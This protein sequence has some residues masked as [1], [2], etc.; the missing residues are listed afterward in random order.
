VNEIEFL[1]NAYIN[2][3]FPMADAITNEIC[4]HSPTYRA[5]FPIYDIKPHRSLKQY[6]KQN[7][8]TTTINKNFPFVINA[9]AN[10][11]E[12]WISNEIINLY[13]SLHK[14]GFAHS[15]ESWYDG[16]I[17]GGLY[18]IS[19]GG[20]FFGESMF[21]YMSN[22]SK[23]AFY[24]LIEHLKKKEFELLDTQFINE[25]TKLLGAIEIPR[26]DYIKKLK[27]AIKLERSFV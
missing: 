23:I 14:Y 19:I 9:C 15:I 3:Y 10:R 18:G 21:S 20:A 1:I 25:H 4:F 8:I 11:E 26:K 22:A 16:N 2:G 13:I 6:I 7:L 12:T 5:I 17:V 27:Y 24:F